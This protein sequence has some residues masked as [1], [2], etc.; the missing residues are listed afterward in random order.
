M[1]CNARAFWL[2]CPKAHLY[3]PVR[4]MLFGSA[5]WQ[6]RGEVVGWPRARPSGGMDAACEPPGMDSRRVLTVATRPPP[7]RDDQ[8][9][10]CCFNQKPDFL[11][12]L[13]GA[14]GR[15]V[16]CSGMHSARVLPSLPKATPLFSS[17]PDALFGSATWQN[18]GEVVGWPRARPS[19]GMD[20]ACEPPWTD[21]RRVLTVAT[22]PP[23]ARDDRGAAFC[24]RKKRPGASRGVRSQV[25]LISTVR[26]RS[27]PRRSS[28]PSPGHARCRPP[29]K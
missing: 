24:F 8:A 7:A 29:A 19:G 2:P 28:R 4:L 25:P 9:A 18:Q 6:N 20:A 17:S 27:R 11:P 3:I 15:A 13:A 12:H 23:P 10:A 14:A 21:S 1:A 26:S 22:R 16:E 5:T